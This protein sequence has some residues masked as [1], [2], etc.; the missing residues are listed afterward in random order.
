[1]IKNRMIK[2]GGAAVAVATVVT[3]TAS[4][5]DAAAVTHRIT[6][7]T[8][9]TGSVA[10]TGKTNAKGVVFKLGNI[11][12]TCKS[13]KASGRVKL[14]ARVPSARAAT[15]ARSTWTGC[16]GPAGITL[17][18]SQKSPWYI[19]LGGRTSA[20]GVTPGFVSNVHAYVHA[21]T[22]AQCNFRVTGAVNGSYANRTHLLTVNGGAAGVHK[23]TV[24]HVHGCFGLVK[25]GGHPRFIAAYKVTTPKG[26]LRVTNR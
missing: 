7:G 24:S 11:K 17:L 26:A 23:L 19:N 5:A 10:F 18:V 21:R 20:R 3:F 1:M 12:M 22:A 8:A 25:G 14:G 13:S 16:R 2:L 15:I 6:A 9:R 4:T